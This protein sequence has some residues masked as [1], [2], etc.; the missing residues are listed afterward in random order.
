MKT[1]TFNTANADLGTAHPKFQIYADLM[2]LSGV[3]LAQALIVGLHSEDEDARVILT[4]YLIK[5]ILGWILYHLNKQSSFK[6]RNPMDVY[7]FGQT[8]FSFRVLFDL[9]SIS[10]L[11]ALAYYKHQLCW[12]SLAIFGTSVIL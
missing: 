2:A 4:P 11:L 12:M 7:H 1:I 5:V 3:A 8:L 10:I 9:I 6:H